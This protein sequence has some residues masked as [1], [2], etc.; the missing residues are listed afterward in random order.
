MVTSTEKW[1]RIQWIFGTHATNNFVQNNWSDNS[2]FG[3]CNGSDCCTS[4][5][6]VINNQLLTLGL[7]PTQTWGTVGDA[8]IERAFGWVRGT[9]TRVEAEDYNQPPLGNADTTA[10]NGYGAYRTTTDVDIAF[11]QTC[12]NDHLVEASA[13]EWLRYYVDAYWPGTYTFM[14]NVATSG[15]GSSIQLEVDGLNAGSVMLP[16]TGGLAQWSQI[17]LPSVAMSQGPHLV[18]LI[19]SGPTFRFD[20]MTYDAGSRA[21]PGTAPVTTVAGSFDGNSGLDQ[22][23]IFVSPQMCWDVGPAGGRHQVWFS[24]WGTGN[25]VVSGDF[26]GNGRDDALVIF[27]SGSQWYWHLGLS[28]GSRFEPR[29]NALVGWSGGSQTLVGDFDGDLKDDVVVMLVDPSDGLWHWRLARSSG[30]S[31]VPHPNAQV[32]HG[33]GTGAC[34]KDYDA[35]GRDEIVVQFTSNI[36]GKLNTATNT[37][38]TTTPCAQTCP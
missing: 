18:R 29:P 13:T 22:L 14:F 9:S 30:S 7:W 10:G 12:S 25:P 35:D 28:T 21:C 23:S 1:G 4:Q 31:F 37:F 20:W 15:T 6:V 17:Q 34:V 36:C 2:E 5:N 11:C 27:Q 33:N 16:N 8:G 38:V 32:G 3:C 24:G 26:D 19:F